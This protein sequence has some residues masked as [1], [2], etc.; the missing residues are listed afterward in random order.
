MSEYHKIHTVFLRDP[1]KKFKT[2]FWGHWARP[3]FKYLANC[4]WVFTEKVDGMNIRIHFNGGDYRILGRTDRADVPANLREFI[5]NQLA[6]VTLE[7]KLEGKDVCL[8][9]EGYGA[10]IQKGGGKYGP[11]QKFVL[12]D[13][14][15]NGTWLSR[16][17][18]EYV[19]TELGFEIV[20]IVDVGTLWD[21]VELAKS[22][23][24]SAWGNFTAEGIVARPEVEM[25]NRHGERIITKIKYKDFKR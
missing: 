8:Y 21:M 14:K 4:P 15:A 1:E 24:E 23:F 10:K 19:A 22:G 6:T 25:L 5:E 17:T 9:G 11:D 18:V 20:P 7:K 3:E 12:F 13:V 16:F 2:L